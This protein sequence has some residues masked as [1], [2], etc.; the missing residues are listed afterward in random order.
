MHFHSQ[1]KEIIINKY[2]RAQNLMRGIQGFGQ[3]SIIANSTVF[4]IWIEKSKCFWYE[5]DINIE[6]NCGDANAPVKKWDKEYRLVNAEKASN[7][8]AFD[9]S[10]LAKA[11]EKISNTIVDQNQ[12]PI[13][14]VELKLDDTD[15][16]ETIQFTAFDRVWTFSVLESEI[17]E[18]PKKTIKKGT[19]PSPNGK[20]YL[21]I[22]DYNLWLHDINSGEENAL[23]QD[24]EEHYC[25]A[26]VGNGWGIDMHFLGDGLQALWSSDSK[27]VLTVQRDSRQVK[28][29]PMVEHV[30]KDGSIRPKLNLIKVALQGDEHVPEYRLVAID[31]ER[32]RL[33]EAHYA[34]LPIIRNSTGFF[35]SRLAWWSTDNQHAY[36]V[37]MVRGYQKVHVVKLDTNTGNTQVLFTESSDTY[38]NLM[39]NDDEFPTIMPIPETNELIWFSERSGWAHLYLYDLK[40]GNLKNAI[41]SGEWLVRSILSANLPKREIF[42]QTMGR[43]SDRDPYYRDIIRVNIDTGELTTIASSNHDYYAISN[44]CFDMETVIFSA[45]G[46]DVSNARAIS[47]QGDYIV[48]TQSRVNCV[49]ATILLDRNGKK[50]LEIEQGD[51]TALYDKMSQQWEWPEPIELLA[52]DNETAIYGVVWRPSDF[53]PDQSYPV[54]SYGFN[55]PELPRVPKGSFSNSSSCGAYYFGGAAL[56]ELGFVVVQI[57][58]TGTPFRGKV[59]QDKSYGWAE[60]AGCIDDHVAGIKQLAERYPYI[61]LNRVGV[62][63]LGGGTGAVQGL[64]HHPDFFKVGAHSMLHDSRLL[65][66]PLWSDKYEGLEGPNPKY[67]YP[68][69]YAENLQG[70]LLLMAGMLDTTI[71]PSSTFRLIEALQTANKDF[72]LI[73]LPNLGHQHSNYLMRR[74]WDFLVTHLLGLFPPE[75]FEL[76]F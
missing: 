74:S 52:A 27:R 64:L 20:F 17:S 8:R 73:M 3:A 22:R 71:F 62:S 5:R 38:L 36:F 41:T 63:T 46:N 18:L 6:K 25:Y 19:L 21:F 26:V 54:I 42:L 23:T 75:G 58:G 2:Q 1:D 53:S 50:I 43:T 37:D 51:M 15:Q 67:H 4:P 32:N 60:S 28:S 33:Q 7:T 56:A 12:L 68:E 45:L 16:V 49:P 34:N 59:F 11:L 13:S 39:V 47:H 57:D 10:K 29:V 61:D 48:A 70:K 44:F 14:D 30:P 72:D 9:H 76:R 66:T 40:T 35:D 55:T 69:A 31:I 24:G 65:T